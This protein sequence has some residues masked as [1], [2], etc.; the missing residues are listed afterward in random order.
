MKRSKTSYKMYPAWEFDR[1]VQ[2]LDEQS[3]KGWQ[4]TK[5]GCFH[6][7]YHFDDSV[8]YRFAL[9]Y[10]QDIRDPVRYRETFAEQGWEFIN[11]TINGWHYFR[12]VFNPDLPEE[13]YQ[14]YTDTASRQEMAGRWRKLAYTLGS[15]ELL[16]GLIYLLANIARPAI[17][18]ICMTSACLLMALLLIGGAK[19]I[20]FPSRRRVLISAKMLI[21]VIALLAAALVFGGFRAESFVTQTE[22]LSPEDDAPWEISFDV[23]LPDIYTIALN[24]DA[25]ASVT[26]CLADAGDEASE[27]GVIYRAHGMYLDESK[28]LFLMPGTYRLLT[29]YDPSVVPG[30]AGQFKYQLR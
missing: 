28:H 1:E 21:P 16:L 18:G 15:V 4:L 13:E 29:R 25:P 5:G 10:T 24:V 26:V 3:A 11:S 6:S 9:D 22:Y 8:R 27:D 14:I 19:S 7:R 12:K 20:R 30:L 23:K 17:H 2:E